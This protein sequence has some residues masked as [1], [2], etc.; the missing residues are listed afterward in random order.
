MSAFYE[1]VVFVSVSSQDCTDPSEIQYSNFPLIG[2]YSQ[3]NNATL[4]YHLLGAVACGMDGFIINWNPASDFQTDII[5]RLFI[6]AEALNNRGANITLMISYDQSTTSDAAEVAGHFEVLKSHWANSSAYFRDD[7]PSDT[8]G[9]PVILFWS[10]SA[11][12]T[13]ST[14]ARS[15]FNDAVLLVVR[16]AVSGMRYSEANFQWV[17]PTDYYVADPT[18]DWGGGYFDDF[19]WLMARQNTSS[20]ETRG[21]VNTLAMGSVWPGFDDLN[22]PFSWNGGDHRLINRDVASGRTMSLTW[23]YMLG[24]TPLRLGG[25]VEVD[26][27]W[28]QVG[29]SAVLSFL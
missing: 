15:V 26:M 9:Q 11:T 12:A 5:G 8:A 29:R 16:N 22:V 14:A 21:S 1:L 13:F 4:E 20:F 23:D 28:V 27:P 25:T 7:G 2:E 18:T 10:S 3:F 17:T 6:Q 19:D 24:Y